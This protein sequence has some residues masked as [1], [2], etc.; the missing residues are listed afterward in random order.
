MKTGYLSFVLMLVLWSAAVRA[1]TP[2][3]P[4]NPQTGPSVPA[5]GSQAP[6]FEL[7][8]VGSDG[9][10]LQLSSLKGKAVIVSFW[11]TWC[12]PCKVEMP[13][14]VELQKKYAEQGL[15]VVGISMDD[16]EEKEVIDFARK[17][18]VNYPVLRGTE[19]VADLYGGVD[20]LPMTFWLDRSGKVVDSR[21]GLESESQIEDSI[22]KSLAN[23]N[24]AN[25][26][27]K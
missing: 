25:A 23:G 11:A 20:A 5:A 15:Q 1:Q 19:K 18:G 6:D 10:T 12:E 13:W 24:L 26:S 2:T 8:V 27:A 4:T 3:A 7:K 22:K 17:M 9:K 16:A 21:V 14:L